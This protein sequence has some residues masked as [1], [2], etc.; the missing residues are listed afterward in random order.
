MLTDAEERHNLDPHGHGHGVD[1]FGVLALV[2]IP[3]ANAVPLELDGEQQAEIQH[4]HEVRRYADSGEYQSDRA[5]GIRARHWSSE[6][7]RDVIKVS[8]EMRI[9]TGSRSFCCLILLKGT[10]RKYPGRQTVA[11]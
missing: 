7:C 3:L 4:E 11:R 2:R 10:H 9:F 8:I 5:T 1:V 6:T